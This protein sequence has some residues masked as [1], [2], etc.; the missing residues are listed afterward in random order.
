MLWQDL[1]EEPAEKWIQR[2]VELR[3]AGR[4]ADADALM[5]EFRRRF[6]DQHLPEDAR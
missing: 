3:R 1:V 4:T 2:L 6:P 5:T